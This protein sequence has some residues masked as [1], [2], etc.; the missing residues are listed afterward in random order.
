MIQTFINQIFYVEKKF[1]SLIN[2]NEYFNIN[3]IFA[4][5]R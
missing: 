1:K 5:S 3:I 2:I 4:S